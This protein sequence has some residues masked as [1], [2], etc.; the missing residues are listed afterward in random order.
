MRRPTIQDG[1]RRCST[2]AGATLILLVAGCETTTIKSVPTVD[3]G[4]R[5]APRSPITDADVIAAG[6]DGRRLSADDAVGT[7]ASASRL[8]DIEGALLLYDALHHHLP[9]TLDDL[10]PLDDAGM[11]LQTNAPSGQ[12]YLY[13]PNGLVTLGSNHRIIVADPAPSAAGKRWCILLPPSPARGTGIS[14]SVLELPE[15]T[16]RTYVPAE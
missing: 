1:R 5:S 14:A 10:K 15:A 6:A 3:T 16:F 7:D 2:V 9:P 13:I 12:P 8:H 4:A 11:E